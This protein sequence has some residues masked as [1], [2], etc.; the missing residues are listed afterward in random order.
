MKH[1]VL[2]KESVVATTTGA[3]VC[4]TFTAA[5]SFKRFAQI[6]SVGT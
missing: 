2:S 4:N 6:R 5:K 1:T 3:E